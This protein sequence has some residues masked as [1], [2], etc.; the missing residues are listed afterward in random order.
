MAKKTFEKIRA[1][2]VED[3]GIKCFRME[4]L[5]D[6]SP[7]KRLGPGVNAEIHEEL[8]KRGLV[9][10]ELPLDAWRTVYV[11]DGHSEAGTLLRV[12]QGT[13]TEDGAST[14]LKAV[15]PSDG[16]A[17]AETKLEE[18]RTLLVQLQDIFVEGEGGA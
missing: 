11:V 3:G 2:V 8:D 6:A 17:S 13:P 16:A 12:L 9:H 4:V 5:R 14:I 15:Q 7:Y 1:E 10:T 18:V